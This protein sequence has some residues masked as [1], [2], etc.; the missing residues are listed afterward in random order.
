MEIFEKRLVAKGSGGELGAD[1]HVRQLGLK[2]ILAD[3]FPIHYSLETVKDIV[4][5]QCN[6]L[7]S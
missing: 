1:Y 3:S 6:Q 7:I 5:T 2:L 4:P